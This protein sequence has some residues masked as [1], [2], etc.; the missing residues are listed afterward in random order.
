MKLVDGVYIGDMRYDECQHGRRRNECRSHGCFRSV[1]PRPVFCVGCEDKDGRRQKVAILGAI[2]GR[3][4]GY[5]ESR[6]L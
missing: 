5:F 2:A 6:H 3:D 1:R 4:N